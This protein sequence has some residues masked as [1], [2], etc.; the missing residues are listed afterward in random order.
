MD[1][2]SEIIVQGIGLFRY[3][4]GFPLARASG[5]CSCHFHVGRLNYDRMVDRVPSVK[6]F[7]SRGGEREGGS[8]LPMS[9]EESSLSRAAS[10]L[11][12][13]R[14]VVVFTG[15]GVSAESGIPTFRDDDGFWQHFPVDDFATWK[16][17]VHTAIY[18][19]RRVAEFI[20]AVVRP[21]AE[22]KP[23]AAHKAIADME[24]HVGV[25]V[26]TQ[27]ID[28]LHREAGSTI[29]HE[30]HGSLFEVTRRGRFFQLL[31]R[32][33]LSR[34]A[35]R[36]DRARRGWF[37]LPRTLLAV[38]PMAGLGLAGDTFPGLSSSAMRW[39]SRHGR[40]RSQPP[41]PAIA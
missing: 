39:R 14:E 41:K 6:T 28:N 22:A 25:T 11:R 16:G 34:M 32:R 31:S 2:N 18:K 37:V 15:A 36:L 29:V 40:T 17:L 10:F 26:V 24:R 27:N 3:R 1:A 5:L 38:R 7:V 21:I 9:R 13:A 8:P 4:H 12:S 19:P 20:H 30:V 35:D 33:Q 23:N